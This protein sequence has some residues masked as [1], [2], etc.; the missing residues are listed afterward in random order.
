MIYGLDHS[1]FN[2]DF[3]MQSPYQL[4]IAFSIWA[5]LVVVY[6][7]YT[8][9][10]TIN[11]VPTCGTRT[12]KEIWDVFNGIIVHPRYLIPID[13]QSLKIMHDKDDNPWI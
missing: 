9:S 2:S 8:C 1:A 11:L 3:V 7:S 10:I 12:N 13:N 5:P 6:I 4:T